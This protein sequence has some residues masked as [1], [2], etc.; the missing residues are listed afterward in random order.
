[1]ETNIFSAF[2]F[3]ALFMCMVACS[4]N[5]DPD[6]EQNVGKILIE[7]TVKNPDGASGSSYLQLIPDFSKQTID[8]KNSI[9]VGFDAGIK[10]L[11]NNIFVFPEFGKDGTQEILRYT[12]D[13]TRN[14]KNPATLTLPPVSGAYNFTNVG[15]EKAYAS[16]YNLGKILIFNPSSMTQIGEIDL[17]S[18]AFDDN[19]PD[20]ASMFVRDG[21]LYIALNQIGP[22][23]M[24]YPDY[25]QVDVAIVN[26]ETDEVVKVASARTSN[27]TFPT[28]PHL[29]N[30][31]FTDENNDLYIACAGGFGLDPRFPETGFVCIRSGQTEFD[32]SSSWDIS[33]TPIQNT[34]YKPGS[35]SNC[36][37]IGNGKLCAFVA[38]AELM[39]N[40]PYTAKYS[41]AV[42]IDMKA[43]T[44]KKIDGIPLSDG[45][46]VFIETYEDLVVFAAYGESEAGFFTYDPANGEVSDGPVISTAGNPIFMHP[47]E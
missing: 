44:I 27:M 37:Y 14:L 46:S 39:A 8:N 19:N 42:L 31:I 29:E 45:H 7:T 10:V 11:G 13:G 6:P 43:K 34:S 9:Q 21:L 2:C 30:M 17:S 32:A 36:K 41:M 33:Q 26:V 47:F 25:K 35:L 18:Y 22:N 38:I 20:P 15:T 4:D 12:Y 1:M 40:N 3:S 23:W 24:P 5:D 28:R 16:L